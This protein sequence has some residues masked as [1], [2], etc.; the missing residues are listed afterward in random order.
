[1]VPTG[2]PYPICGAMEAHRSLCQHQRVHGARLTVHCPWYQ[3]RYPWCLL[4]IPVPFSSSTVPACRITVQPALYLLP[5]GSPSQASRTCIDRMCG[6]T[7]RMQMK[8][9]CIPKR[10]A[11]IHI[12]YIHQLRI[13][14]PLSRLLLGKQTS[15]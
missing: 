13:E 10:D 8:M 3:A 11:H 15:K 1:M 4:T 12:Y 14:P 2:S 7:G 5:A 6:P 9:Y